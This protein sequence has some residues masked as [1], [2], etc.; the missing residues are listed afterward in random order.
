[1]SDILDINSDQ[2]EKID[3]L[4]THKYSS[5]L[6][7]EDMTD[8]WYIEYLGVTSNAEYKF[9]MKKLC[10]MGTNL[11][12]LKAKKYQDDTFSIIKFNEV[13]TKKLIENNGF[14][15]LVEEERNK[16]NIREESEKIAQRKA[17]VDLEL[18]EKVLKN[19]S[20]TKFM[21]IIA[22]IISLILLGFEFYKVYKN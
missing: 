4:F 16:K 6:S 5:S 17:I 18:N 13:E 2:I 10:E 15:G 19:Y 7:G 14:K 8:K 21:S 1:M 11:T 12:L 9:L 22:F 3:K 20:Y